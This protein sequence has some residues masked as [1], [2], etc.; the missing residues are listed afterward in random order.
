MESKGVELSLVKQALLEIEALRKEVAQLK[1]VDGEHFAIVGMSCRLPG[2]IASPDELWQMVV[3][4]QCVI[5]TP[6]KTRVF[7]INGVDCSISNPDVFSEMR[8]GYVADPYGMDHHFLV[9]LSASCS[10]WTRNSVIFWS[11]LGKLLKMRALTLRGC[12]TL[13]PVYL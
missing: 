6:P 1:K 13:I 8:G 5:S 3:N 2:G 10:L 9:Y 12:A 4:Q 11:L 7:M